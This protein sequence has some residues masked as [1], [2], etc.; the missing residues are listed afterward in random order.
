MAA[1]DQSQAGP[2]TEFDGHGPSR[3]TAH[4]GRE[5]PIGKRVED[6]EDDDF[7]DHVPDASACPLSEGIMA[8][9]DR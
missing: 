2:E 5:R 3:F 1:L 4:R 7:L 8:I 9:E 6:A